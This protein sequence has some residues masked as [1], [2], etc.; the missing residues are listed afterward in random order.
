MVFGPRAVEAIDD[1]VSGPEASGAMRTVL[2]VD[3]AT[4]GPWPSDVIG[5]HYL[6]LAQDGFDPRVIDVSPDAA[7]TDDLVKVRSRLQS[8]LTR[9]AGVLRDAESLTAAARSVETAWRA[10]QGDG[11]EAEEIRNLATVGLAMVRAAAAREESRGA[12][13]RVDF[14]ERR[15]DLALRFV[16]T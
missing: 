10:S 9:D 14:P 4:D 8:A 3:P 16:V 5:G 11:R 13:A 12:H 2:D 7:P 15:P 1:G 6:S